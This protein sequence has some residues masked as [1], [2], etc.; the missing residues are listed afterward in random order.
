MHDLLRGADSGDQRDARQGERLHV[1]CQVRLEV[2]EGQFGSSFRSREL[3]FAHC[4]RAEDVPGLSGAIRW[5]R[6]PE[7]AAT[8]GVMLASGRVPAVEPATGSQI[9]PAPVPSSSQTSPVA[10]G[11]PPFEALKGL[12][13]RLV[14]RRERRGLTRQELADRLNYADSAVASIEHGLKPGPR[15]FWALA[16][17]A[18]GADGSLLADADRSLLIWAAAM[19]DQ[20]SRH[21]HAAARA[22]GPGR[23]M[24]SRAPAVDRVFADQ[25]GAISVQGRRHPEML[26]AVERCRPRVER[27]LAALTA[28]VRVL[29]RRTDFTDPEVFAAVWQALL[30]QDPRQAALLSAVAIVELARVRLAAVARF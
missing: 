2:R 30:R 17:R 14:V 15:T 13:R 23:A 1:V 25:L 22:A 11:R 5:Q 7:H 24:P 20:L 29:V 10:C 18:L 9:P 19:Q 8:V 12:G 6:L 27:E 28:A 3:Q 26:A 21:H 4:A 16:D